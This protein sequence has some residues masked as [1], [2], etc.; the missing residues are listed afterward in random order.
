MR[1]KR[2]E[3]REAKDECGSHADERRFKQS[4]ELQGRHLMAF[5]RWHDMPS[6]PKVCL[7]RV[8][9]IGNRRMDHVGS[10]SH[11]YSV[12]G[13]YGVKSIL[14]KLYKPSRI[15]WEK[16]GSLVIDQW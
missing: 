3:K 15:R 1:G 11:A 4:A 13:V 2:R 12:Y 9:S 10:G 14:Y 16:R 5:I 7:I 6:A 8:K